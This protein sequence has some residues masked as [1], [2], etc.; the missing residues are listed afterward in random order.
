MWSTRL[1]RRPDDRARLRPARRAAARGDRLPA[2]GR[3][4]MAERLLPRHERLR[5][6]AGGGEALAAPGRTSR[7][8]RAPRSR[9]RTKICAR[10]RRCERDRCCT[11]HCPPPHSIRAGAQAADAPLRAPPLRHRR[12]QAARPARD[13]APSVCQ[14][15]RGVRVPHVCAQPAG[16]GARRATRIV[17]SLRRRFG[18]PHLRAGV[19]Q[20]H[21]P[22]HGRLE[23]HLVRDR[24]RRPP[25]FRR[26]G[27]S[28][29]AASLAKA[30][31]VASGEI[32]DPDAERHRAQ[33]EPRQSI[34]PRA[35]RPPSQADSRRLSCSYSA[36]V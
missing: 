21:V 1:R 33:R 26:D 10:R 25:A 13:R 9:R 15:K 27:E 12:L 30:R 18:R 4:Q 7:G 2:R 35:R 8:R 28:P 31:P 5:G 11:A 23:L 20:A 14:R 29:P 36:Q 16:P 6:R 19:A 34:P 24:A 3:N 17:R 32:R 22:P